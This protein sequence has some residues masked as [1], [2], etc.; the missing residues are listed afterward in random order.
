MF[1]CIFIST[2]ALMHYLTNTLLNCNIILFVLEKKKKKMKRTNSKW[3]SENLIKRV[4]CR[5]K[6]DLRLNCVVS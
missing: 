6:Y 5:W 3:M 4:I 2:V 1:L